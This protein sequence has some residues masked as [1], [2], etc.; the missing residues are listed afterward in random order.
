MKK[1]KLFCWLLPV[2]CFAQIADPYSLAPEKFLSL[3]AVRQRFTAKEIDELRLEAT[4]FHSVNQAR[5]QHQLSEFKFHPRL[6]PVARAHSKEMAEMNYF[7]HQSPIT[8]NETMLQRFRNAQLRWSGQLAENIAVSFTK[9]TVLSGYNPSELE[10]YPYDT[11]YKF[12]KNIV[13]K[14]LA[15]KGHR[16][17]ILNPRLKIMAVGVAR[18]KLNGLDAIYVTQNFA[19]NILN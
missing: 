5:R 14:W 10:K 6:N 18:G 2:V 7:S 13:E 15:S 12:A 17:N 4:I 19:T 16:E 9:S 3:P 11:Y 1:L 8:N